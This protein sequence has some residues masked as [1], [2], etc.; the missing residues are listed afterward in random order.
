MSD[1]RNIMSVDVEEW[2]HILD[3][4]GPRIQQWAFLPGRV[5]S[6]FLYLL[7]Q[8]DK[9]DVKVTCFFLGWI[10]E[11]YPKLVQEA[12]RR[13]HEIASHG[14]A[15]E[16][17]QHQS[18]SQFAWDVKKTK[19][20]LEQI[21]G[22]E[23]IGYRAPGFSVHSSTRWAL[24]ELVVAGYR[25]DSSIFPTRHGHGGM[26]GA[27]TK[28]HEIHTA[29]GS[30]FEF[31]ISIASFF[32][33]PTC[34]FGGGYLRLFPYFLIRKKAGQVNADNR[35][36]IFYVHPREVDPAHPRLTMSVRRYFKSYFNLAS[37][38]RKLECVLREQ[39]VGPFR[40]WLELP[41]R[42]AAA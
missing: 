40:R 31:P 24:E 28:P 23:V 37:T 26:L 3:V 10:A 39:N 27:Q 30:I 20:I 38:R 22:T 7:D 2:F 35:P 29:A 5:E 12:V 21:S 1:I 25:Y 14:Y 34:F 36:V 16:L 42:V 33:R 4:D 13:Q 18:R 6:N 11:R 8:F 15:H 19:E 9:F 17:I 41:S 32:G